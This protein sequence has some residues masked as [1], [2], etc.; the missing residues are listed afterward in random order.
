[1]NIKTT[2]IVL[3]ASLFAAFSHAAT[4]PFNISIAYGTGLSASQQQIFAQAESFWE[5]KL[6]G[7]AEQVSFPTGLTIEA[8][9]MTR[10]G[11]GGVLGSA[12]PTG[13]YIFNNKYY[14]STA[15][16]QFDVADLGWLESNSS[17]YSVIVHEM[18]H[19]IGFGTLWSYNGLYTNGTG[20]YTGAYA[21]N[22]YRAEFDPNATFIPVELDGG[23]GT[24]NGHWDESWLGGSADI[25]TGY[26]EGAVTISNTTLM[27]FRDLGYE[28]ANA[29]APAPVSAAFAGLGLL[30][31]LRR[32]QNTQP[33]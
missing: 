3:C 26:L 29:P 18:A 14:A 13:A 32:R 4:V 20:R 7:Y 17:L 22:A 23:T 27:S 12:G 15:R 19:A 16:M 10:D 30:A 5:S 21:L 28:I 33:V 1:M 6:I 8:S 24:A 11:V 31:L 25:M 9:G 2:G